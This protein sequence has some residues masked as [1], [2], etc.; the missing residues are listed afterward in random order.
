MG[1]CQQPIRSFAGALYEK[2][3]LK[4]NKTALVWLFASSVFLARSVSTTAQK[5]RA[6]N[7]VYLWCVTVLRAMM[8]HH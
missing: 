5:R 7:R 4:E 1:F 3:V 6:A 2:I 8:S